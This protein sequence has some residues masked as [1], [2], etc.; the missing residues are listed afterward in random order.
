MK[1]IILLLSIIGAMNAYSISETGTGCEGI[2][3]DNPVL[4]GSGIGGSGTGL[5]GA[6]D[7]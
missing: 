1:R 6:G 5:P 7:I 4:I 2:I 3:S